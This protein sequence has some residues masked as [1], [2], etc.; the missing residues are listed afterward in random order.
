MSFFSELNGKKLSLT[1]SKKKYFY[2]ANQ[3]HAHAHAHAHAEPSRTSRTAVAAHA[4]G[5]LSSSELFNLSCH[6][7][8]YILLKINSPNQCGMLLTSFH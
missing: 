7:D 5:A 1:W 6:E 4:W 2:W 3:A 8:I